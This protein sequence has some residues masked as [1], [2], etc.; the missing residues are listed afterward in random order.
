MNRTE[1]KNL[2]KEQIRGNIGIL[3][4]ITILIAVI[5]YLAGSVIGIVP[6]VGPIAS[7]LFVVASSNMVILS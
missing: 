1:I 3:F 7:V 4:V 5:S 6:Y 2:A